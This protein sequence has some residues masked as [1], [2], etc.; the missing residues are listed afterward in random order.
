MQNSKINKEKFLQ[1]Y[2]I[3]SLQR[4]IKIL[5][6]FSRLAVRDK[7]ES[8]LKLLPRVRDHVLKRISTNSVILQK[9]SQFLKNYV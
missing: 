1:D 4:N 5:G 9:I 2:E 7:K 8:Y 6:I 3:L